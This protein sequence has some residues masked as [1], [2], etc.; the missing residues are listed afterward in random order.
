MKF[1]S[2]LDK[3]LEEASI[4][5]CHLG[6]F[7]ALGVK[8]GLRALE[9]FGYDPHG[10]RAEVIVPRM[11]TPYTCFAD[12]IQY[13]TGCT[14]GKGNIE[15]REGG[16]LKVIFSRGSRKLELEVRGE[17]LEKL[18]ESSEDMEAEAKRIIRASLLDIFEESLL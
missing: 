16:R 4:L 18:E 13:V 15:V 10:M 3:I 5:H 12:G 1:R 8:A 11:E 6:P 9:V 7:L 14:L 17:A 2:I